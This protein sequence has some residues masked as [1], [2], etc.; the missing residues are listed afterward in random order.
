MGDDGEDGDDD[1]DDGGDGGDREST[2]PKG[3]CSKAKVFGWGAGGGVVG[4]VT[5]S[6]SYSKLP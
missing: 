3:L 2:R 6:S 1:V 5:G 4:I